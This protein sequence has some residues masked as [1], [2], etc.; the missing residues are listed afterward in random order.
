MKVLLLLFVSLGFAHGPSI[1]PDPW[2]DEDEDILK[3]TPP[4]PPPD[5]ALVYPYC[6]PGSDDDK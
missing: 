5:C 4:P 1:P 2:E 6:T 3:P